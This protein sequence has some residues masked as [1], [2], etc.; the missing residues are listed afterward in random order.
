QFVLGY[1]GMPRRYHAYPTEFQI[2]NVLSS[3]G[4]SILGVGYFL[5]FTYLI[6]SLFNGPKAGDN[7]WN[8]TGLEWQIPSPPPA[9]DFSRPP[10]VTE[11]PYEYALLDQRVVDPVEG[12][13][14]VGG[15]RHGG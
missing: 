5:P 15:V 14:P 8:A 2:L 9:G 4:A 1:L 13:H 7:P 3:A 10:V 11:G 12:E 6:V